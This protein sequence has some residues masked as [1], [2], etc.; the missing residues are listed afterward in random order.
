MQ[1]AAQTGC[2]AVGVEI[3]SEL[4]DI[5]MALHRNYKALVLIPPLFPFPFPGKLDLSLKT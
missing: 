3:R 5:A 4:T 2:V 1:A